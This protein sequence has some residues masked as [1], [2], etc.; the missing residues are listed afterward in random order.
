[1]QSPENISIY[2]VAF[3][4]TRSNPGTY[5]VGY[6]LDPATKQGY[7]YLPGKADAAYKD[8]VWLIYRGIE[9]KWFHASQK[10]QHLA[11]PL[12]AKSQ[13]SPVRR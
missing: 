9:G 8:N 5:V 2:T 11:D 13:N 6:A 7:V 12:I 3:V 4:T 1:M 10:W